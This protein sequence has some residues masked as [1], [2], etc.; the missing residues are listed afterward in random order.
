MWNIVA[1]ARRQ[2]RFINKNVVIQN[3]H[4]THIP[5]A[6]QKDIKIILPVPTFNVKLSYTF[7]IDSKR[8]CKHVLHILSLYSSAEVLTY[9]SNIGFA[10]ITFSIIELD[11]YG[12]RR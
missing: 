1:D 12:A 11:G 9:V 2:R 10:K 7:E 6:Y 3:M 5:R 8:A 4:Y